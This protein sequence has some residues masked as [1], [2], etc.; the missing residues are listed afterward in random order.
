MTTAWVSETHRQRICLR[1]NLDRKFGSLIRQQAPGAEAR[2]HKVSSGTSEHVPFPLRSLEPVVGIDIEA[3]DHADFDG[4][5]SAQCRTKLPAVERGQDFAGHHG[6]CLVPERAVVATV[7]RG[8]VRIRSPVASWAVPREDRRAWLEA[9]S[10]LRRSLG[11]GRGI[12]KR[13]T[14][15]PAR[16]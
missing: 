11:R 8:R 3:D 4:L 5:I 9:Q 1:P 13:I 14:A 16:S 10:G 15:G 2:P 6:R 12:G 7:R